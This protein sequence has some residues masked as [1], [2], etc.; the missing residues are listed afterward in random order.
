MACFVGTSLKPKEPLV[1]LLLNCET[2]LPSAEGQI[3]WGQ[4]HSHYT[5]LIRE[6]SGDIGGFADGMPTSGG[7]SQI[8]CA[9]AACP[10]A[11][12]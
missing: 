10:P 8:H 9:L 3:K 5:A 1:F 6:A 7:S 2:T 11:V 12:L 4:P